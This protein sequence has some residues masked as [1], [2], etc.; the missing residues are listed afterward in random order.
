MG[1]SMTLQT[2][3]YHKPPYNMNV[4]VNYCTTNTFKLP[5]GLLQCR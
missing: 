1:E 2:Q 3:S 5:E 4:T